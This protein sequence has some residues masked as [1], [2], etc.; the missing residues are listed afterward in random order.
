MEKSKVAIV[1]PALNEAK[2]IT[3]VIAGVREYGI[4]IVVNDGST[5]DT[6]EVSR[7]AG[8]EV[9][10]H[11]QNKGYD[12]A[13][14]SG[15]SKAAELGRE[16]II[17]I[18]ADG[19]HNPKYMV[20]MLQAIYSGESKL[21]LAYRDK[22]ARCAE[23]LFRIVAK[24]KYGINDILCGL[25][26]FHVD[27]FREY[28]QIMKQQTMGTGLA[29]HSTRA[30]NRPVQIPIIIED[31]LDTPRIGRIFKANL[32]IFKG[33]LLALNWRTSSKTATDLP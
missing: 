28:G 2:T 8:A 11:P 17:S 15:F 32:L 12:I 19:Q 21:A 14:Y 22:S 13:L 9:V 3:P 20:Q 5:D 31:R 26:A 4:V 33:M 18:D 24:R 29:I 16:F 6:E 30:G 27:L 10:T 1:I 7:N 25:K 23:Y